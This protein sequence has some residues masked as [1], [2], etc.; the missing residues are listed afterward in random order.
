MTAA[1]RD[2]GTAGPSR[3]AAHPP[4]PFVAI[5]ALLTLILV[6]DVVL[7]LQLHIT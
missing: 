7:L 2:A 1:R 5:G 6:V 3:P 4:Y